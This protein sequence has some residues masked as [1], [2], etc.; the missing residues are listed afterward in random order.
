M[1]VWNLTNLPTFGWRQ[2]DICRQDS[3]ASPLFPVLGLS[4]AIRNK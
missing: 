3:V 1:T 2:T 4:R